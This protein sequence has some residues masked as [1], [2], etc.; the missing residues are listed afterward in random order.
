MR[1]QNTC[2]KEYQRNIMQLRNSD[3]YKSPNA[4]TARMERSAISNM[5]NP[6]NFKQKEQN[7]IQE[8]KTLKKNTQ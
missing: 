2:L 7:A 5:I 6:P 1:E 4:R 3:K 8:K